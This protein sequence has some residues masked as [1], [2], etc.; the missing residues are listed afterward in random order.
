VGEGQTH[1]SSVLEQIGH[2]EGL[3]DTSQ[4][5]PD[6]GYTEHIIEEQ[7]GTEDKQDLRGQWESELT[8]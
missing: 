4:K 6:C 2:A 1:Y 5:P 8:Q 7:G 3:A